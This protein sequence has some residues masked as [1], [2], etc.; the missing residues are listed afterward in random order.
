MLVY[1]NRF[2][3]RSY[4]IYMRTYPKN[5]KLHS[6]NYITNELICNASLYMC[7]YIYVAAKLAKYTTIEK[8]FRETFYTVDCYKHS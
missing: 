7:S 2:I 4:T 1:M 5:N 6:Y 8:D 3:Y